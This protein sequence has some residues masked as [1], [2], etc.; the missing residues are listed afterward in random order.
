MHLLNACERTV[1]GRQAIEGRNDETHHHGQALNFI[2]P[3]SY[4][5]VDVSPG[6]IPIINGDGSYVI[7][8][9][10]RVF[11]LRSTLLFHSLTS[12]TS[13]NGKNDSDQQPS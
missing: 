10:F 9:S 1:S 7:I 3:V 6:M 2:E 4:G 8:L 11:S 13:Q 5:S 12:M